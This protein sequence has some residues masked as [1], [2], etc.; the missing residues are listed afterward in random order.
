MYAQL[1]QPN[2]SVVGQSGLCLD[3][4]TR[5]FG[6]P[7]K[8]DTATNAWNAAQYQHTNQPPANAVPVW[9]SWT[10][11]INGV[12]QD[13]GHVA[14]WDNGTVYSTTA[15]GDKTFSGIQDL[16]NYIGEG[17][18]YR[19]WS[20]DINGVRVVQPQGGADMLNDNGTTIIWQ[21]C[22]RKNPSQADLDYWRGHPWD[23]CMATQM[24]TSAYEVTSSWMAAGEAMGT[25]PT[26]LA[27]GV[28]K[29]Q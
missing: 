28:Y 1:V 21:T 13:W 2:L 14:V 16:M 23:V 22:F 24:N 8:Y 4:V 7:N 10:G 15:Q 19:G 18:Q 20:E 17:I 26:V 12:T 6:I 5:V 27:S 11:T 25:S 29:V 9:F 3:Y